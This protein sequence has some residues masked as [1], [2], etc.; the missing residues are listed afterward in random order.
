MV[1][2]YNLRFLIKLHN[3]LGLSVDKRQ[4]NQFVYLANY[5]KN[6][7]FKECVKDD[8]IDLI[9]SEFVVSL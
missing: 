2:Y 8:N 6:N 1:Y 4:K 7:K 9:I 5:I 3:Q